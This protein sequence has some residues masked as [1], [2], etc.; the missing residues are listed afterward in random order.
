MESRWCCCCHTDHCYSLWS[1]VGW[2]ETLRVNIQLIQYS[3]TWHKPVGPLCISWAE[4]LQSLGQ[5]HRTLHWFEMGPR[6]Y[7]TL[8]TPAAGENKNCLV[9]AQWGPTCP[10]PLS[11]VSPDHT[12]CS[13]HRELMVLN[14]LMLFTPL[15][16]FM[17][18][19]FDPNY[20]FFSSPTSEM[21][22]KH[23]LTLQGTVQIST[24]NFLTQNHPSCRC[25]PT[26]LCTYFCYST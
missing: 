23:T 4:S 12:P 20:S 11:P 10:S 18:C 2:Q 9:C 14:N 3:H 6:G 24:F 21:F 15:C 8:R 26:T 19:S 16:L 17:Y 5:S 1:L 22:I 7:F 25:V 13:S